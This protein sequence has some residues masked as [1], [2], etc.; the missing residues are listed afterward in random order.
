[1]KELQSSDIFSVGLQNDNLFKWIIG[2]QG[3][4]DTLYEVISSLT[5]Q[6]GW[7]FPDCLRVPGR[8]SQPASQNEVSERHVAP[9]HLPRWHHLHFYLAQAGVR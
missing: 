5:S 4:Q 3:Q 9:Q 7:L 2:F 1:M 8:I 6:L